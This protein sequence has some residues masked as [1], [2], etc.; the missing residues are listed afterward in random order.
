MR[1]EAAYAKSAP[2]TVYRLELD[3]AQVVTKATNFTLAANAA[4]G[5]LSITSRAQA[6]LQWCRC[7]G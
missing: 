5:T 1:V 7:S 2:T 6:R 4:P 3:T